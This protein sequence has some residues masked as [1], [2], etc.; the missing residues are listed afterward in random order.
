MTPAMRAMYDSDPN[1]QTMGIDCCSRA[2]EEASDLM[3]W[4]RRQSDRLVW[5]ANSARKTTRTPKKFLGTDW[6]ESYQDFCDD[7]RY[8]GWDKE[9]SLGPLIKWLGDGPGRIAV[10]D[11]RMQHGENG[12]YDQLVTSATLY[13]GTLVANDPWQ[14]FQTR[15]QKPKETYKIFG[16]EI[17]RLLQRARPEW[18]K[19]DEYFLDELF[20]HYIRGLRD[21]AHAELIKKE[22]TR[23]SSMVDFFLAIDQFEKKK[24]LLAGFAPNSRINAV[25]SKSDESS[26]EETDEE[27]LAAIEGNK[28]R[29]WKNKGE[30]KETKEVVKE[31]PIVPAAGP[32][33]PSESE[34]R[35]VAMMNEMKGLLEYRRKPKVDRATVKCFRCQDMGHYAAECTAEKPVWRERRREETGN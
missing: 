30:K 32:P 6:K 28:K 23:G 5:S 14:E 35:M 9:A 19:D 21:P 18:R 13:F 4:S 12:T 26:T 29:W 11:W 1:I 16:L 20:T 25:S 34:K 33:E 17:Q 22:W 2:N 24:R 10:D 31:Q 15:T 3:D 7:N 27:H 8:H